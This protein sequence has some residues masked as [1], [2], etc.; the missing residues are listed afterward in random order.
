MGA[1]ATFDY[2]GWLARYPEFSNVNSATASAYFTE[3]TLYHRN[4][5]GGLVVD[6]AQQLLLLNMLT[7]HIAYLN[8]GT[9]TNPAPGGGLVGRIANATEGSVSVAL[10]MQALPGTAAWFAQTKYGMSYWQAMAPYR[11]A[12]YIPG[13]TRSFEPLYGRPGRIGRW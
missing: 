1:V 3:A 7:A 2:T 10:E 6:S 5:G 12:R 4:D 9:A 11:M 13:P 8:S